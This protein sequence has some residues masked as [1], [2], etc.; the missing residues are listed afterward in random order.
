[1]KQILFTLLLVAA[2][3]SLHAQE[4]IVMNKAMFIEK[5]FDYT[6]KEAKELNVGGEVLCYVY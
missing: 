3:Y 2:S 1:M 6:D 4:V 5:V